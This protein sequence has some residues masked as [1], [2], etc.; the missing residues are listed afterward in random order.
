MHVGAEGRT[1][2][3]MWCCVIVLTGM[4]NLERKLFSVLAPRLTVTL[5][6]TLVAPCTMRLRW[7]HEW[8]ASHSL[9]LGDVTKIYAQYACIH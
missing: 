6:R 4:R 8:E 7:C 1:C 9:P 5:R 2:A 3:C